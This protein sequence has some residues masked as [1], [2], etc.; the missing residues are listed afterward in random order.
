MGFRLHFVKEEF[1]WFIN[2]IK[3]EKGKRKEIREG[4]KNESTAPNCAAP[5]T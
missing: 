4:K 5:S 3:R 2:Q 1:D